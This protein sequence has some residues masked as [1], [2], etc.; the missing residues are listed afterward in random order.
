MLTH[1]SAGMLQVLMPA[2]SD[3]RPICEDRV[4]DDD[5]YTKPQT[6]MA[7]IMRAIFVSDPVKSEFGC[8]DRI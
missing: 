2:R 1:G 3:P 7:R 5:L 4:A 8:G 6:K